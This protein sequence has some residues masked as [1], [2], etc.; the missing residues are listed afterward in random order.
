MSTDKE[1]A[2]QLAKEMMV[3]TATSKQGAEILGLLGEQIGRAH[4]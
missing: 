2:F 3:H 4:V 1:F